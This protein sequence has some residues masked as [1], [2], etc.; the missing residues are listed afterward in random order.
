[1][2]TYVTD[3]SQ[4]S[5]IQL[6]STKKEGFVTSMTTGCTPALFVKMETA[7]YTL[8]VTGEYAVTAHCSFD[9]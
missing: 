6:R 9:K 1:M 5:T 8:T 2:C 4:W 7:R 3:D